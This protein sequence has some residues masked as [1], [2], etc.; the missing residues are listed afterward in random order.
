VVLLDVRYISGFYFLALLLPVWDLC[1]FLFP[2]AGAK[3]ISVIVN[4]SRFDILG[5]F[6]HPSWLHPFS[7]AQAPLPAS[8]PTYQP[9]AFWR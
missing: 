9:T 8:L 3:S 2:C 5:C 6:A 1:V 4:I 7:S